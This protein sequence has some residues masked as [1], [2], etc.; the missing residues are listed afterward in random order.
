MED[1]IT[2][3]NCGEDI[4]FVEYRAS[5]S[6]VEWGSAH[7]SQSSFVDHDYHDGENNDT[8][9]YE[10]MCPECQANIDVDQLPELVQQRPNSNHNNRQPIDLRTTIEGS[11]RESEYMEE[12]T[13]NSDGT[14]KSRVEITKLPA[15]DSQRIVDPE[16]EQYPKD[17]YDY[18]PYRVFSTRKAQNKL[19]SNAAQC[20]EC[21]TFFM[22]NNDDEEESIIC[23]NCGLEFDLTTLTE[24]L[25]A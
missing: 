22:H 23:T 24:K 4:T 15:S 16:E 12:V 6:G 25:N 9:D 5:T 20:P 7:F 13:L 8:Y 11:N 10:Y 17:A 14:I 19:P 3:P 21:E 18:S 2:C 1:Y